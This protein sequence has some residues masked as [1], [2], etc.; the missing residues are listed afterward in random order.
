MAA[1]KPTKRVFV[2]PATARD[3]EDMLLKVEKKTAIIPIR[4]TDELKADM[5]ETAALL[6]TNVSEM[7]RGLYLNYK[8]RMVGYKGDDRL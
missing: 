5:E 2:P 3:R 6:D 8:R 7:L 1:K 4:V